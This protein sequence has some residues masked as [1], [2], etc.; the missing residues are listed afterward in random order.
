MVGL[1]AGA[2]QLCSACC[3]IMAYQGILIRHRDKKGRH[4]GGVTLYAARGDNTQAIYWLERA[5]QLRD[6]GLLSVKN[7]PMLKNVQHD[8]RFTSLM[9]KLNLAN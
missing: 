3:L 9:H 2:A 8:P 1:S 5:Y 6:T 7:D 4:G